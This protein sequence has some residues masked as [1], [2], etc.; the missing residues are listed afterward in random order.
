[1]ST[2]LPTSTRS[3]TADRPSS[4]MLARTIA[5]GFVAG[6]LSGLFGVGGGILI[7]PALVL[8][9]HF[10]QRLAH[11]TSLA[12]VL[13]IAM[14]SLFSY[15]LED[16]VDWSVGLF[17]ASG[18]VC[19]AVVG[20]HILHKLPHR[21]LAIAFSALL[22]VTAVRLLLDHSD[23]VGR[24]DLSLVSA[25]VLVAVGLL[26][27]ILSGLL[28]VGGG[29]VM[30]P[31]MV[32]GFG[33][34]AA[35]AKGTSLLVIVPTAVVGTWRNRSKKNADLRVAVTLGLA[36]VVSAFIAGKISVGM[37]ETLSNVLFSILLLIVAAR[38]IWQLVSERRRVDAP[39]R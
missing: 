33:I 18:A 6:F 22:I 37:S 2:P 1:M 17:L 38:M 14:S 5:V 29:I 11:G 23:A 25:L 13:P 34:P 39:A 36:G 19:G 8:V 9:L 27:G 15:A 28:G 31:A 4:A 10:D 24:S 21:V 32:V 3:I 35:I 30:V 20:T 16:K 12:S 7:V 26:T